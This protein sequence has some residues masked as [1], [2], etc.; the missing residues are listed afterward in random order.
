[1]AVYHS[2]QFGW[3]A[4]QDVSDEFGQLVRGTLKA[5]DTFILDHM[6]K[7]TGGGH[8]LPANFTLAAVKGGKTRAIIKVLG[9]GAIFAGATMFNLT[10]WMFWALFNLIALVAALKRAVERATLRHCERRRIR[11]LRR[12]AA[13][14]QAVQQKAEPL[15]TPVVRIAPTPVAAPAPVTLPPAATLAALPQAA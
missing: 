13:Q 1:M 11:K 2:S 10:W 12:A 7:V 8:Q 3:K 9:R 4:G 14:A 15:F 6:Y 5:G